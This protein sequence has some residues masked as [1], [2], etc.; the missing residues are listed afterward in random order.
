VAEKEVL[1]TVTPATGPTPFGEERLDPLAERAQARD[2]K[3]RLARREVAERRRVDALRESRAPVTIGMLRGHERELTVR[4]A[5]TVLEGYQG[6]LRVEGGR[7]LVVSP[8]G[9]PRMP[10]AVDHKAR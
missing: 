4:Q 1:F 7:A 2:P 6:E 5:A 8:E 3:A 9:R 10:G